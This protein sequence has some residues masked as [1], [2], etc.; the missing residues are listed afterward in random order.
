VRRHGRPWQPQE[1]VL[2]SEKLRQERI[3]DL[4]FVV[5]RWTA[6]ELR[7]SPEVVLDRIRRRSRYANALYGV[8]LL[9]I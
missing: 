4:G 6:A 8:P 2:W 3:E 5:V 7:R 9:R 1:T